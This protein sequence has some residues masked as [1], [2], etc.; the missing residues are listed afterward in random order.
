[1]KIQQDASQ[2]YFECRT[3][4]DSNLLSTGRSQVRQRIETS[5]CSLVLPIFDELES[6]AK[7]FIWVTHQSAS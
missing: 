2:G 6:S 3:L 4:I 5:Y 7:N 1:M